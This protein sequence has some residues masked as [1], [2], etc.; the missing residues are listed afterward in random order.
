MVDRKISAIGQHGQTRC[1][2]CTVN[3]QLLD[4]GLY[5]KAEMHILFGVAL[6][7]G[8]TVPYVLH[9]TEIRE[10]KYMHHATGSYSEFRWSFALNSGKHDS[11]FTHLLEMV[12]VLEEPWD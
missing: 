6:E 5:A 9:F 7:H 2:I 8:H 12:A 4:E 1:Y 11:M 3:V 10:V